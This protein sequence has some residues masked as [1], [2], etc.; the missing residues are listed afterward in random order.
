MFKFDE[1]EKKNNKSF[2]DLTFEFFLISLVFVD[3]IY[4]FVSMCLISIGKFEV[5][6]TEFFLFFINI[7]FVITDIFYSLYLKAKFKIY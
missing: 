7:L 1:E 2:G 5:G 4:M 6:L 3:V